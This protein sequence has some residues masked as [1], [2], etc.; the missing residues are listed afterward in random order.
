MYKITTY[1]KSI[2]VR[3]ETGRLVAIFNEDI[4]VKKSLEVLIENFNN[5]LNFDNETK[6]L[7]DSLDEYRSNYYNLKGVVGGF[8]DSLKDEGFLN[9]E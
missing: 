5:K 3:D 9:D 1:Q 6:E 7:S 2:Y 8:L 4:S